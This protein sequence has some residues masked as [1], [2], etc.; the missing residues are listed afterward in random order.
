MSGALLVDNKLHHEYWRKRSGT[1]SVSYVAATVDGYAPPPEGFSFTNALDDNAG[2]S[3]KVSN[4]ND[5]V[6][7]TLTFPTAISLNG[8]AVY[9]HNLTRNQGLKITYSTDGTNFFEFEGTPYTENTYKPVDNFYKPFGA[10]FSSVISSIVK[11]RFETISWSPDSYISILSAGV[12]VTSGVE[13]SAPFIPPTFTTQEYSI[14][15]NNK[16][17]HL[18]SDVRRV[19]T[20]LSINLQ[21]FSEDELYATSDSAQL[22]TINGLTATYPFIEYMGYFLS[23]HPFFFMYTKGYSTDSAAQQIIDQQ[24]IYFCTT[25]KGLKPPSYSSPTLLDWKINALGYIE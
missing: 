23:R 15:R 20:K 19:P 24:K 12:W 11:L 8:F 22:T 21:K 13:I 2:T 16:G 1:T 25:D 4:F 9:G 10:V 3:F 18:I 5:Q 6:D 7:V 17:N 14:K